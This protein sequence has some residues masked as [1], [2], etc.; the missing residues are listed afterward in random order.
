VLP[1]D[2]ID[3]GVNGDFLKEEYQRALEGKSTPD[4]RDGTCNACGLERWLPACRQI[5]E[6]L[7]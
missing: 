6:K 7:S 2:H 4:C 5:H 1:W 3:V